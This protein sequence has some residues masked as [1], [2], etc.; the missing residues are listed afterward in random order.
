MPDMETSS[1]TTFPGGDGAAPEAAGAVQ[2]RKSPG[3]Q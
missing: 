2:S 1:V 3:S